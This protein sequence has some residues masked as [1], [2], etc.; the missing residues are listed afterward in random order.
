MI[1]TV[2]E[3]GAMTTPCSLAVAL[4]MSLLLAVDSGTTS[5][6]TITLAN[7][8]VNPQINGLYKE[9][10]GTQYHVQGSAT[11][12]TDGGSIFFHWCS[13]AR[14]FVVANNFAFAQGCGCFGYAYGSGPFGTWAEAQVH[15][16]GAMTWVWAGAT[17]GISAMGVDTTDDPNST[18][19]DHTNY[20]FIDPC[21]TTTT[22]TTTSTSTN[23]TSTTSTSNTTS[24]STTTSTTTTTNTTAT[25]TT[26]TSS[27]TTST[28]SSTSTS[29]TST[30]STSTSS[31]STSSTS[32]SSTTTTSATS[33]ATTSTSTS[34]C[35]TSTSTTS[36]VTTASTTTTTS[37]SRATTATTTASAT[38]TTTT[39]TTATT[40]TTGTTTISITTTTTMTA[41]TTATATTETTAAV[42]VLGGTDVDA[43][44][45]SGDSTNQTLDATDA[46]A[47]RDAESSGTSNTSYDGQDAS[48][49]GIVT[50]VS[51]METSDKPSEMPTDVDDPDERIEYFSVGGQTFKVDVNDFGVQLGALIAVLLVPP[52]LC[53]PWVV[54]CL[55]RCR[56]K[57]RSEEEEQLNLRGAEAVMPPPFEEDD[58]LEA[59][60]TNALVKD[61]AEAA[62][63]P[64]DLS[65][66]IMPD[67]SPA[68]IEGNPWEY[69]DVPEE[70]SADAE[71]EDWQ[72]VSLAPA[73]APDVKVVLATTSVDDPWQCPED[74]GLEEPPATSSGPE[75]GLLYQKVDY[76]EL[77]KALHAVPAA[78]LLESPS[79][80]AST[81]A[82][83]P[84]VSAATTPMSEVG[85]QL[86][87]V[88]MKP[89]RSQL[90]DYLVY[91]GD[92]DAAR[93]LGE[94]PVSGVNNPKHRRACTS[95]GKAL[96]P[97]RGSFSL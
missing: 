6:R 56:R 66:T 35:T 9:R 54:C 43:N 26:T 23:T 25:S 58:T 65:L 2:N 62:V 45:T 8:G 86:A 60:P 88:L 57:K 41:I 87:D 64:A 68:P 30:S 97:V 67:S 51:V 90:V 73:A 49:I 85:A 33:T 47:D 31:T 93:S 24:T 32:T 76:D 89:S 7:F 11:Y 79:S 59:T 70:R 52:V 28:S 5:L 84:A 94:E 77:S 18:D 40:T 14:V 74:T 17:A 69:P 75:E 3:R 61:P 10:L 34:T 29:S 1:R 96:R 13:Q 78:G 36:S 21:T 19:H 83:D 44:E 80:S 22:T 39:A 48:S 42:H 15:Q 37:T 71:S 55:R 38:T 16:N 63:T 53:C 91:H 72:F 81:T 46:A 27:T 95:L 50:A 12:W 20:T 4:L 92:C 82:F